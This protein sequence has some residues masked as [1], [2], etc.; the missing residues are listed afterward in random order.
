LVKTRE[1][2]RIPTGMSTLHISSAWSVF[3]FI[4]LVQQFIT[5]GAMAVCAYRRNYVWSVNTLTFFIQLPNT[6]DY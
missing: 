6:K 1:L 2:G 5:W 4:Y 3:F